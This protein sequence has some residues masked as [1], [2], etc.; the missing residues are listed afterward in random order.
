MKRLGMFILICCMFTLEAAMNNNSRDCSKPGEDVDSSQADRFFVP[1][2][3]LKRTISSGSG[4]YGSCSNR[5]VSP[6]TLVPSSVSKT[7]E[8]FLLEEEPEGE[9]FT[10][11]H[12]AIINFDNDAVDEFIKRNL[13]LE[14]NENTK[15]KT[16]LHVAVE[17]G[18]IYAVNQL[19]FRKVNIACVDS[20]GRTSSQLP[21]KKNGEEIQALLDLYADED[22]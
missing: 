13:D 7:L 15:K 16:P 3:N 10:P 12:T 4:G 19:L 11:F 21:S 17:V 8:E 20:A 22:E 1:P 2:S 14:N 5:E 18:N 6:L 9:G